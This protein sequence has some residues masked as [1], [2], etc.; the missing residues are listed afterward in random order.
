MKHVRLKIF[1]IVTVLG[2]ALISIIAPQQSEALHI[3]TYGPPI[4]FNMLMDDGSVIPAGKAPTATVNFG[5]GTYDYEASSGSHPNGV[6]HNYVNE[7]TIIIP[8]NGAGNFSYTH[9]PVTITYGMRLPTDPLLYSSRATDKYLS[10]Y[11]LVFSNAPKYIRSISSKSTVLGDYSNYTETYARRMSDRN[12]EN[13]V[14]HSWPTAQRTINNPNLTRTAPGSFKYNGHWAMSGREHPESVEFAYSG[15]VGRISDSNTKWNDNF[16]YN[17]SVSSWGKKITFFL[18]GFQTQEIFRDQDGLALTPPAGFTQNKRTNANADVFTHTMNTLPT[19]YNQGGFLYTLQGWHQ[20]NVKPATLETSNPPSITMDYT[21]PKTISDLDNEGII[22]V[23]Y[24]KSFAVNEKYVDASNASINGG[25]WDK[26]VPTPINSTFN[27]TP[28]ATKTDSSNT[29]WDYVG[30]KIGLGGTV[31]SSPVTIANVSGNEDIYYIYKKSSTTAGLDLTPTPQ[32]VNSGDSVSWSSR[33]TNTGAAPL[34]NLKLKATSN[35]A[36][37]LSHPTQVTVTPAGGS[38]V[39]FTVGAGDWATGVDLTGITIPNGGA[40]NY[41]DITFTD[42]AT[43]A[44]NQVLPAE[45]EV[46]GNIPAPIKA[47]NFVRIDDPDEPN[48]EPSGTA[49][50]I[51]LPDFRFGEVEVKPYAQKKGLDAAS[52]QSGYKPYIRYM[53]NESTG[54]Y[55]LSVKMSPFTSGSKTLPS[56]TSIKLG[57]GMMKEVQNYNKHNE[58]LSAGSTISEIRILSDNTTSFVHFDITR[59]VYQIEYAFNEVELDLMAHSGVAG[60]S[61]TSTMDWTLTTAP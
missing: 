41:A 55:S 27:G 38:P 30:W 43:G 21:Q 56:T 31:S 45:I 35:W 10:Y 34:N 32:I 25:A 37:G 6:I 47:D 44:V 33:L 7:E 42:T 9:S 53:D 46:A 15:G 57:D 11:N 48:L 28:D 24:A 22:T 3:Q 51:N 40:N 36:S 5:L 58:S 14:P 16:Y 60:L 59:G 1:M 12:D 18:K 29:K 13:S 17:S 20:T 26:T 54:M 23:V 50:L 52:Y 49:G 8:Y 19:S 39:N 61:Y 4:D 2:L